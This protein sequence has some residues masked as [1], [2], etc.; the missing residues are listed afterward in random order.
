MKRGLEALKLPTRENRKTLHDLV[1]AQGHEGE[2][3]VASHWPIYGKEGDPHLN[4][5]SKM[6]E[7][8]EYDAVL[9]SGP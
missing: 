1:L 7:P 3:L 4:H 9:K 5:P 2:D 6:I 8:K